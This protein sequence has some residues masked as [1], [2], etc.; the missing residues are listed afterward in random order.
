[1]GKMSGASRRA[2]QKVFNWTRLSALVPEEARAE[3][4]AFKAKYESCKASLAAY[5]EKTEALDWAHYR[6]NISAKGFV[7][8][9][10]HKYEAVKVPYPK[11]TSSAEIDALKKSLEVEVE[12]VIAEAKENVK[13]FEKL[14]EE[15]K[16]QKPYEEMTIDEYLADKPE[17]RRKI[18]Q[19]TKN[20]EWYIP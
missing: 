7:D 16:A 1:M 13:K 11:D 2:G 17:L 18:D 8:N 15:L 10:Q 9:F 4:T 6:K 14:L 20:H 5:P 3:F 19:D 12:K